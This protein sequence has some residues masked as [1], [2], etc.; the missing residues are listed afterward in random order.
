MSRSGSLSLGSCGSCRGSGSFL[1][2][3][4]RREVDGVDGA[5]GAFSDALAAHLAE[6]EVDV[7]EVVLDLDSAEGADLLALATAD[8][9]CGA[10]LASDSALF[11]VAAS[12][13][14]A[15]I[16]GAFV[17][18]LDDAAGASLDASAT[19][20]AL[21]GVDDGET[22]FGVDVES[23]ELASLGAVAEAEA[24]ER[25]AAFAS[26]EAVGEGAI[27]KTI[28]MVLGG[29]VATGA[30]ATDDG[31]LGSA[32]LSGA[33]QESSDLLGDLVAASGTFKT[34]HVSLFHKSLGH[35][36]ATSLTAAAAV[37]AWE[38]VTHLIDEGI[39]FDLKLLCHKIE[40]NCENSASD[41]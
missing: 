11:L 34:I 20:D 12:N 27:L 3:R 35:S 13:E 28:E 9:S 19:S 24:A 25:A 32:S 8:A 36:T 10:G 38:N 40:H 14:N 4:Q 22:R 29:G 17:A 30:V 6:V 39:L 31:D 1:L 41:A 18:E 37:G 21:V 26:V 15:M 23:V 16:L 2:G 5:S 7:S 33:A